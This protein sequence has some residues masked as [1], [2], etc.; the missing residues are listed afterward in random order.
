MYPLLSR[1]QV[2]GD[3][4]SLTGPIRVAILFA[5]PATAAANMAAARHQLIVDAIAGGNP[6][7]AQRAVDTHMAEAARALLAPAQDPTTTDQA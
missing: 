5:G 2:P 1:I 3:V 7:T 6:D 4:R